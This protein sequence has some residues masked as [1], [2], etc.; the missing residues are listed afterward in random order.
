M[1]AKAL[2]SRAG[3]E[4]TTAESG[5]E[6]LLLLTNTPFDAVLTDVTMPGTDGSS[7]C[8]RFAKPVARP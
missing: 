4:V 1:I 7:S 6:A 2:A 8:G 5:A 3:A